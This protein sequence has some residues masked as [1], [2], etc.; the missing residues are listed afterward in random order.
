MKPIEITASWLPVDVMMGLD[1]RSQETTKT[2]AGAESVN[3]DWT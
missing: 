2:G 3:S 1:T